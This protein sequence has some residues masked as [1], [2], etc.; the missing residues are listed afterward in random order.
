MIINKDT[1]IV[2]PHPLLRQKAQKVDLPLSYE[3][4]TLLEAMLLYVERSQDDTIA[5]EE[6]LLPAVGIAAPQVGVS[7][8]MTAVLVNDYDEDGEI[9]KTHRFALVNPKV[10]SYS[11]KKSALSGGEGCLSIRQP[12]EGYVYRPARV[13]ISAYDLI[14]DS[15]IEI[16]AEGYLAI[17]LQ[18][19]IDHLRGILF[20]DHISKDDPWQ[21]INN[22]ELI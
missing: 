18:H 9:T 20:Y 17:V 11:T 7:K 2:D 8:Q 15:V 1:I 14:S 22:S 4:R 10:K 16:K 19:E 3:D 6:N 5:E 12:H 21:S 13:V